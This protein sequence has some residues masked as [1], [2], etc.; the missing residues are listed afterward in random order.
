[1]LVKLPEA[2]LLE[3]SQRLAGRLEHG[4]LRSRVHQLLDLPPLVL[5]RPYLM[6][7]RLALHLLSS[8]SSVFHR[9]CRPSVE[10]LD[11]VLA[12]LDG[13]EQLIRL[14]QTFE[15]TGSRIAVVCGS[16]H[17][18]AGSLGSA[19]GVCVDEGHARPRR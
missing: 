9:L 13:G 2:V 18:D 7:R 14:E 8:S 4:E 15:S 1:M 12:V 5:V 10:R 19:T 17:T 3:I 11:L 16:E 6:R